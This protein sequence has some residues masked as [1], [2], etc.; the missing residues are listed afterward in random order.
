MNLPDSPDTPATLDIRGLRLLLPDSAR[1][2]LDGVDL[3]VAAGETVALVGESGS[4]K[5]LTAR[6]VLGLLP[7]G[8]Q[9]QGSVRVVGEDVLGMSAAQLRLLRTSTAAMIFQDPRAALNPLRR[10]GDF[11]TESLRLNARMKKEAARARAVRMLE[12]VGLSA[13]ALRTYPGQLS[14]GMLQRVM[15]AAALM[16]DP[17]LILADE[18]TTALDVTTQ[19]E[20]VALLGELR[21]G[22]GTGLLFV[23]HDLGLAAAISDRVYVMYAGRIAETGPAEE[24]FARPRHPYTAALLDSTPRLDA[25]RGRL[26]AI[27]GRPPSLREEVAGCPFAARCP[28]ASDLC[29]LEAPD[30][31]PTAGG[32]PGHLA[33]CHHTDRVRGGAPG[34]QGRPGRS[35]AGKE[36][37]R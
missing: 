9:A 21:E 8:A 14:G 7:A 28:H 22:F 19:A 37:H 15:I 5:T 18:P 25:P 30:L 10:V 35:P 31:L 16:G 33:S 3:T 24:L 29:R 27:E 11:L 17:A 34:G 1:P 23:T 32:R 36:S 26:A 4:G 20:V 12:A 2:V 6:S 13:A